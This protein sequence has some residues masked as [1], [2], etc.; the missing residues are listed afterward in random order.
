[1]TLVFTFM[2][3]LLGLGGKVGLHLGVCLLMTATKPALT[4]VFTFMIRSPLFG[5]VSAGPRSHDRLSPRP[6]GVRRAETPAGTEPGSRPPQRSPSV[7]ARRPRCDWR[8]TPA[9]ASGSVGL[10]PGQV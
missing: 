8:L 10:F 2:V 4:L 1:L 3:V 6:Q 5:M 9:R 7:P